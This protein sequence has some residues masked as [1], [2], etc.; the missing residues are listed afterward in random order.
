VRLIRLVS[1]SRAL[2]LEMAREFF[3]AFGWTDPVDFVLTGMQEEAL[4]WALR[5]PNVGPTRVLPQDK[6]QTRIRPP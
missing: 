2:A 4:Q 3:A 1:V 5:V 6:L